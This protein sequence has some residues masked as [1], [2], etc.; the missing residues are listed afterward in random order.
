MAYSTKVPDSDAK[1]WY[2]G[3]FR[4]VSLPTIYVVDK[5]VRDSLTKDNKGESSPEAGWEKIGFFTSN[6]TATRFQLKQLQNDPDYKDQVSKGFYST[7]NT[8]SEEQILEEFA[9]NMSKTPKDKAVQRKVINSY[10][11]KGKD[12]T[13]RVGGEDPN[14]ENAVMQHD[15]MEIDKGNAALINGDMIAR[16][17]DDTSLGGNDAINCYWSYN[18]D[19][20]IVHPQTAYNRSMADNT[21]CQ[22]LGMGRVYAENINRYQQILYINF[23]LPVYKGSIM[24]MFGGSSVRARLINKG[25]TISASAGNLL[26]TIFSVALAIPMLPLY[27]IMALT[28]L[29][30]DYPVSKYFEHRTAMPMYYKFC[31]MLIGHMA[32][33]LG[34]YRA[35]EEALEDIQ[36]GFQ[37]ALSVTTK[38]VTFGM[39]DYEESEPVKVNAKKQDNSLIPQGNALY[40][41]T[42][43]GV[44]EILRNGPDMLAIMY[45]RSLRLRAFNG[46][47]K[48][49][50]A[51]APERFETTDAKLKNWI[52]SSEA[53][54]E[55]EYMEA[56]TL[57]QQK[58]NEI[59]KLKAQDATKNKAAIEA[60][61]ADLKKL[62]EMA[63]QLKGKNGDL[64]GALSRWGSGA[65]W[66]NL[67]GMMDNSGL[68]LIDY[69]GFRVEKSTAVSETVSNTTGPMEI[70]GQINGMAQ[71]AM[72]RESSIMGSFRNMTGVKQVADFVEG[73]VSNIV[74]TLG[75]G[76]A[77]NVV[78]GNGFSD[79]P[80]RWT[81]SSFSRSY[82][83]ELQLRTR[84]G[85]AVSW[86]QSV[87][88][89]LACILAGG[90]PRGI[91]GAMYTSPFL[92]RCYCKG[93]FSIPTGIIE[94]ISMTRGGAEFGWSI[95]RLPLSI[96]VNITLKDLS[97][98][99]YIGMD[100]DMNSSMD[101]YMSTL[102]GLG[103]YERTF[104]FSKFT[105]RLNRALLLK[106]N[107][108]A[109]PLWWGNNIGNNGLVRAIATIK[110]PFDRTKNN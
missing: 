64:N 22:L 8:D 59:S 83:V 57:M 43:V 102:T 63:D 44:P 72:N 40:D 99:L 2:R 37:K 12:S 89:P 7:G 94:S 53:P 90:M 42:N 96:D 91:G 97:P 73:F 107:T 80:E 36:K 76:N 38:I 66:S 75:A 61:E 9:G 49:D 19:D 85:D 70:A 1:Q 15:F 100:N 68:Q 6:V 60:A 87:G 41:K 79:I 110:S 46:L 4:S 108:I 67:F 32:V 29:F 3:G 69:I 33:N 71:Q 35:T 98:I 104:I 106:R 56:L 20:D 21:G 74:D 25:N 51:L 58:Q 109:N 13:E 55:R 54:Y 77:F 10:Y 34:L 28:D 82:S 24:S 23:G 27:G 48:D 39:V 31:N 18:E 95:N 103:L 101:E 84:Y 105:R 14:S 88:I 47:L 78:T 5:A 62:Q 52:E 92:V 50:P 86:L 30:N 16:T 17:V 45:K 11:K 26:G 65:A 93:M 81:S